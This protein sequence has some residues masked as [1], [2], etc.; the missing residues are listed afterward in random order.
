MLYRWWKRA[1]KA[2][3]ID[4]AD[5]YSGT[6]QKYMA[7]RNVASPEAIRRLS[8]RAT[9]QAVER[10]YQKSAGETRDIVGRLKAD[11]VGGNAD[12]ALIT[13]NR[14][15]RKANTLFFVSKSGGDDGI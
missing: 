13:K 3:E 15:R 8:G 11:N 5:L 10:Y 9:N 6:R 12:N 2:L 7:P 1:C 14:V 4:G